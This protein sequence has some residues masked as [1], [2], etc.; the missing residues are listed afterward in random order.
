MRSAMIFALVMLIGVGVCFAQCDFGSIA[1][2][3]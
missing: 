3:D 2:G 1:A